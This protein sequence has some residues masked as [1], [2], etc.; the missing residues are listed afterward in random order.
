MTDD[1][2][3][4]PLWIFG[5]GSLLWRPDF[6]FEE[7]RPATALG[8]SR[9]L[10]Q[11]SP[12]HRGVPGALGRVVTLVPRPGATC[13]GAIFRVAPERA[14]TVLAELDHRERGGYSRGYVEV[15]L[16]PQRAESLMAC[17]YI[18]D[19]QNPNYLGPAPLEII[20]AQVRDARGPSGTNLEYVLRLAQVLREISSCDEELCAL[21][22]LL[23][24]PPEE[25]QGSAA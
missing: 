10:W 13:S 3:S 15:A 9:Q 14:L 1:S 25:R 21:E 23:L 11:G 19:P 8:W 20:A 4:S 17:T 22:R 18:A 12:D 6:P 16:G 7:C 24:E 2:A 5:Y